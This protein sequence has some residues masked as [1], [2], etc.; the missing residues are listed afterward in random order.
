MTAAAFTEDSNQLY[1]SSTDGTLIGWD[2]ANLNNLGAQ[3]SPTRRR[4]CRNGWR[5]AEPVRLPS[6]TRTAPSASGPAAA[7]VSSRPIHVSDRPLNRGAFSP[8]GR[9]LRHLGPRGQRRLVDVRAG[10]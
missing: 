1:T 6:D 5:R 3:L 2:I 7:S 10:E 8:D 4:T 9:L